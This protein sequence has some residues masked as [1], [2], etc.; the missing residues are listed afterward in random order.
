MTAGI[1]IGAAEQENLDYLST[2]IYDTGKVG[3]DLYDAVEEFIIGDFE[4]VRKGLWYLGDALETLA[5]DLTVCK[6]AGE[7][8]IPKL[9]EMS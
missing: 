8:D 7:V 1:L 9:V 3:Y 6:E 2:C 5:E 4:S